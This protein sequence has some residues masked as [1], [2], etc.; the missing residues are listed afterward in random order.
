MN[1]T[2]ITTRSTTSGE[3]EGRDYMRT[4]FIHDTR[5]CSTLITHTPNLVGNHEFDP[6]GVGNHEF[7][8]FEGKVN[9]A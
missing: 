4:S 1:L 3:A 6:F 8:P 9:L 7:D 5:S 2:S